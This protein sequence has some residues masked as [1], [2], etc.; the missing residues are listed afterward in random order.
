MTAAAERVL[1]GLS[2]PPPSG[3]AT[4]ALAKAPGDD[5]PVGDREA[6]RIEEG[7][8]D[9]RDGRTMTG[10]RVRARLGP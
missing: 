1:A 4:A 10:A 3:P 8:R 6:E 7:E 2:A 9:L 5:E